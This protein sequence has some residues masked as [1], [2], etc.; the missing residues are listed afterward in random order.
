MTGFTKFDNQ[1]LEKVLTSR[2]TKR[3]LKILLLILRYS[4]GYQKTYAVLRKSDFVCAGVPQNSITEE[5]R[6]LFWLGVIRWDPT[7]S[8]VWINPHLD[9]WAVENLGNTEGRAYTIGARNSMKWQLAVC[10]NSNIQ[11]ARTG[12]PN[13]KEITNGKISAGVP[14]VRILESYFLNVSPLNP[15]EVEALREVARTYG[16][17]TVSRAILAMASEND[18]SFD[19]FLKAVGAFAGQVHP[20]SGLNSLKTGVSGYFNRFRRY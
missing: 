19:R 15:Y 20:T 9:Q 16:Y 8:L 14:F 5:L 7:R 18:R 11:L 3:Q 10:R 1:L 17:R 2:L 13:T 12:S 6:K 4:A